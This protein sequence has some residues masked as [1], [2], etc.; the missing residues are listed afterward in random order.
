MKSMLK[1]FFITGF[2]FALLMSCFDYFIDNNFNVFKS[3][4]LFVVYGT[5]MTVIIKPNNKE[6]IKK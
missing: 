1:T 3:L 4:V 6:D 2:T 5:L